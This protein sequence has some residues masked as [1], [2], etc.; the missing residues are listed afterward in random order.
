MVFT[1][2]SCLFVKEIK[3]EGSGASMKSLT[4][5]EVR[6]S[7]PLQRVCSGVLKKIKKIKYFIFHPVL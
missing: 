3:N 2:F 7:N 1:I 6:S 4:N 5:C